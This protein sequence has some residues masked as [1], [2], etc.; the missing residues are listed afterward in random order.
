[1]SVIGRDRVV[2]G[3]CGD[4]HG[5]HGHRPALRTSLRIAAQDIAKLADALGKM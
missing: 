4:R 5:C 3:V 2:I 1:M